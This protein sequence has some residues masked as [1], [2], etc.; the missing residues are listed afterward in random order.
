ML[1]KCV[2]VSVGLLISTGIHAQTLGPFQPNTTLLAPSLNSVLATKQDYPVLTQP[3]TTSDF[4]AASTQ[5]VHQVVSAAA[6][7]VTTQ[8]IGTNNTTAASTAFVQ[9]A[10]TFVPTQPVSTSNNTVASTAFVQQAL[11]AVPTQ[12]VNTNNS[13]AA[14]TQFVQQALTS[15]PTQT[16][17]T[18]NS[19]AASTQYVIQAF[20]NIQYYIPQG[21]FSDFINDD[22][23]GINAALTAASTAGGG[24][25][26]LNPTKAYWSQTPITVPQNVTLG[27]AVP[28]QKQL[29]VANYVTLGCSVYSAPNTTMTV[30]GTLRN[31]RVIQDNIHFAGQPTT[32]HALKAIT[33]NYSTTGTGIEMSAPDAIIEDTVVLGFNLNIYDFSKNRGSLRNV[34]LEGENCLKYGLVG[35]YSKATNVECW[36]FYSTNRAISFYS[37]VISNVVDNGSGSWRVSLVSVPPEAFVTGD[38]VYIGGTGA[39][40]IPK[41]ALGKHN[42]TVINS[43]TFDLTGSMDA[44]V[45]TVTTGTGS[46]IISGFTALTDLWPGMQFT[47]TCFSGTRTIKKMVPGTLS[48]IA[49]APA[50]STGAC[51]LTFNLGTF[52]AGGNP[53]VTFDAL[54]GQ[55]GIGIEFAGGASSGGLFSNIFVWCHDT[56]IAFDTN[57]IGATMDLVSIDCFPQEY[58][59]D[60]TGLYFAPGANWNRITGNGQTSGGT[61]I[62]NQNGSSSFGQGNILKLGR[63]ESWVWGSIENDSGSMIV[64]GS[65]N[66]DNGAAS[67]QFNADVYNASQQNLAITDGSLF[68]NAIFYGDTSTIY[69]DSG[70]A[71]GTIGGFYPPGNFTLGDNGGHAGQV[72]LNGSTSGSAFIQATSTG[73]LNVTNNVTGQNITF[74]DG[75][76]GNMLRVSGGGLA[77]DGR[78]ITSCTPTNLGSGATCL[79][80]S[81][82]NSSNGTV[83]ITVGTGTLSGTSS[84]SLSFGQN[85]PGSNVPVCVVTLND[86]ATAWPAATLPP[87]ANG[88]SVSSFVI[89]WPEAGLT[90]GMNY[91]LSYHCFGK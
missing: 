90:A 63:V 32:S 89:N 75:S 10:L 41:G 53:E 44:P 3:I 50:I 30:N 71:I 70:S 81:G 43:Q 35:D 6:G 13:T 11:T 25:V 55:H 66:G 56:A 37:R 67:G 46:A 16:F 29:T 24:W 27:C 2:L 69:I 78:A 74:N 48:V 20:P 88:L 54:G 19:T 42:I 49:D 65:I 83:V 1:C 28:P 76:N 77:V 18:S 12:P 60:R 91:A 79:A 9:Q 51:T 15:V 7:T 61:A 85:L 33:S 82:S 62:I 47:G 45:V 26:L 36:P 58:R 8:P 59:S 22:G 4:T 68:P 84:F 72:T 21:T 38:E 17:G 34:L 64:S 5:F 31:A 80:T 39:I 23:P 52:S 86:N 73:N 57:T 40:G 87:R 14:S